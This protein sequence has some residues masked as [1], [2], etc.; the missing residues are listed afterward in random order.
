[1]NS[2]LLRKVVIVGG[3]TAG[4]M[5]AS[6]CA[7]Y[8]QH[9]A[10]EIV[11]VESEDIGTVGVGE[12]TVPVMKM[13]NAMLGIDEWDFV[14]E[15]SGSFKLGIEFRDWNKTG[16]HFF[17]GFGD[18]GADIEGIAA[19]HYWLQLRAQGDQ[20]PL[21]DYSF[22]AQA[23][24]ANRFAPPP[25]Q[26]NNS[27]AAY[28]YA[29]HFDASL[30]AKYLRRYAQTRGV[31]RHE[32][33]ITQVHTNPADGSIS[34]VQLASGERIDGDFFIDCSGFKALLI[35]QTLK[36][37]YCDWRHWLPCDSA[38]VAPCERTGTM[39][40]YTLSSAREA[41]WQWRIPLQHRVGNGYVYASQFTDAQSVA[42]IF[43]DNLEAPPLIEPRTLHFVTG[44]RREF[45]KKN[46]VALGLAAGFLEPLESSSI[47]LIQ[48][49]LM[50]FLENFPTR[51]MNS[52]AIAEYNRITA[53]EYARIR[54]FLILHYCT[55][56]RSEGELWRYCRAMSVPDELQ[57]KIDVFTN[58][59]R[60]PMLTE[61]SYLEPS[62]VA[63]F[64]GQQIVPNAHASQA[65]FMAAPTLS[66]GMAKRRD[67]IQQFVTAM[68]DHAQFIARVCAAQKNA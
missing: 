48:T 35:E 54:D 10:I 41:G 29:Y 17:H 49:G 32:G 19:H 62:W 44:H 53:N 11:L 56:Q 38:L 45:W 6:A 46:C 33:E 36:A 15:T 55:N 26:T 57:H 42:R 13:F 4:W 30:Y 18:F 1:M 22:P 68:P 27:V 61:E 20:T 16:S 3:G 25:P 66:A 9:Q 2:P 51:E 14:K 59:G 63:I 39:T 37:G 8:L 34:S 50:R 12:A 43:L 23:A 24:Y 7:R 28:K 67:T 52:S 40:P 58:T 60:V 47:Q 31:I 5:A 64:I 65:H 21:S